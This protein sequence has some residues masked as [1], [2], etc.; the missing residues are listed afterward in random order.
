L[1][2][3]LVWNQI[4][5]AHAAEIHA[6]L[7]TILIGVQLAAA[8]NDLV[9]LFLALELVSIPT[10][11]LLYLPRR[12]V[13]MREATLKYFL[14]SVFSSALVLY[15][16]AWLFGAAGTTGLTG[17]AEA[18]R[19]GRLDGDSLPLRVA[20]L[21]LLAGLSFRVTAVPFHF[22]APD[23]FQGV[24]A[25]AAAMLSVV[26]KIV[27]F[28]A[29]LRL[30]PLASVGVGV[31]PSGSLDELQWLLTVIAVVTMFAGNLLA[32]RQKHLHRLLAYSSIAHAGYMLAAFAIGIGTPDADAIGALLFYL[33][34]YAIMTI[35]VFAVIS[36]CG[37]RTRPLATDA[38]L[39][40]LSSNHPAGALLMAVCLFSLTGLPPTG[41]FLG[42]FNLFV[43]A[44]SEGSDLARILAGALALNAAIAAWY[45]LRLIA[46]MYFESAARPRTSSVDWPAWVSAAAC[47]VATV[48]LFALP[49]VPW[50]A[51]Q[52]ATRPLSHQPHAVTAG[53]EVGSFPLAGGEPDSHD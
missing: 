3:L 51:A 24:N 36:A 19:M 40:G 15:G 29:L 27:G 48:L 52:R 7:L 28:V 23:V 32:L 17:I 44:W 14:L 13:A 16:M 8:A 50:D 43:A 22:Y 6:C 2:A 20:C 33:L 12:D 11:V 30:V 46:V 35:G 26:P 4:D 41:G 9:T 10:Y 34:A 37:T 31:L 21:L 53:A 5:D 47:T 18:A 39:A 45:Y 38:D 1:L 25:S 49:Q 42:K